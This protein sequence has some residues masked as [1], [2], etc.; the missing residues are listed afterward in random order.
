MA[1][2][3]SGSA[4]SGEGHAAS[5]RAHSLR[6]RRPLLVRGLKLG[7]GVP[8]LLRD[9]AHGVEHEHG[10]LGPDLIGLEVRRFDC[11]TESRGRVTGTSLVHDERDDVIGALLA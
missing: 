5:E 1:M 11:P 9:T 7:R 3:T 10:K 6:V 4:R 8:G 2:A